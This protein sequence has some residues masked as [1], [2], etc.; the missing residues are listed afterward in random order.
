MKTFLTFLLLL[1]LPTLLFSQKKK[2][3]VNDITSNVEARVLVMKA[4][5]NNFLAKDFEPFYGFGFSGQLMTPL[6]FG[7]GLEYNILF[8]D[9]KYGHEHIYNN[10]GAQN[11]RNFSVN[12]IHQ[13][14]LSE[15]FF[16]EE[17]VGF[18][19]NRLNSTRLSTQEKFSEGN[20]GANLGVALVYI[21]D[22]NGKQNFVFGSKATSY[23]SKLSNENEEMRK[24]Y[25]RSFFIGLYFGYRYRF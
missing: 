25:A 1:F 11:L 18:A 13:D 3:I 14:E 7:L 22:R 21:L 16:L 8:S 20:G 9:L 15:E 19:I 17:T 6:H 10:L 4:L 5:G 23:F 12:L 2:N 24:Y